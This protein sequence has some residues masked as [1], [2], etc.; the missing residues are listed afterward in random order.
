VFALRERLAM[1]PEMLVGTSWRLREVR[2]ASGAEETADT[3]LTLR[4]GRGGD[5]IY[6]TSLA[7]ASTECDRG[8]AALLR[9]GNFTTDLRESTYYRLASGR[10]E[11]LTHGGRTLTFSSE[12]GG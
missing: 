12:P 9:E 4:F 3:T 5:R 1:D 11:L 8:E 2:G 7:M 10:L 6:F